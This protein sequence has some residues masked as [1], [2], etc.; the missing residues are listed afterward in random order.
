MQLKMARIK[1]PRKRL[2][3]LY[4]CIMTI[5]EI[6]AA[7]FA[8]LRAEAKITQA[9]VAEGCGVSVQHIKDLEGGRRKPSIDLIFAIASVLR[10]DSSKLLEQ[11]P[12][13]MQEKPLPFK[14]VLGLYAKL[15]E[16]I[17]KDLAKFKDN[18]DVWE[19]VRA[20]IAIQTEELNSKQ[21]T[22]TK[23]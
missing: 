14:S 2:H 12:S 22:K 9:R 23:A 4:P 5:E 8:R 11:D 7:N 18:D 16:D 13:P 15:P 1:R 3:M 19:M 20:A 17:V 6:F 10:V 21:E